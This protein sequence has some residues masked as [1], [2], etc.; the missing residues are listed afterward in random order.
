MIDKKYF[1]GLLWIIGEL[2]LY[3]ALLVLI[4]G[5]I[6]LLS[7]YLLSP[8]QSPLE[9]NGIGNPT[10][11]ILIEYLPLLIG[12]VA[13]LYIHNLIFDR[14]WSVTGIIKRNWLPDMGK[15]YGLA[16]GLLVVGFLLLLALDMI[17]VDEIHMD[18]SLFVGFFILFF[19]QSSFEEVISRSFMISSMEARTNLWT[20]LIISSLLFSVLHGMNPNISFISLA[21]IFMAGFLLGLIFIKT[22]SI[23][24]A[25]GLHAGWNFF[26]GSFFGYEVSGHEVYSYMN[27][28]EHG[29]DLLTG[30]AFGY[31]GSILALISLVGCSAW[32]LYNN[33][34]MMKPAPA[35]VK[36]GDDFAVLVEE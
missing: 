32:M 17:R 7:Y 14:S 23:W 27:T 22:R 6:A 35:E 13:A 28:S 29:N 36:S 8:E 24:M 19:V 33:P 25:I 12:S 5:A 4:G 20:A 16:F 1:L 18:W 34:D 2:I 31:E 11:E 3:T 30:G 9:A 10:D 15:G 26:Q 21:N